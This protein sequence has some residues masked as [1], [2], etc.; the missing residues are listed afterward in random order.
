MERKRNMKKRARERDREG[1]GER[2][3]RGREREVEG[4][5]G[6]LLLSIGFR[7]KEIAF[8]VSALSPL[9]CLAAALADP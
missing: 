3:M 9:A 5:R 8:L 1:E 7:G 6:L 4:K 2:G